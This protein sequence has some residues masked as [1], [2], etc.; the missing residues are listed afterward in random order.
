ER[1]VDDKTRRAIALWRIGVLGSLVSARLE[2]GDRVRLF[3]EIAARVYEMPP[4]GELVELSPR[5]IES[6]Y[7]VYK[8]G[9]FE[10]LRPGTRSDCGKSRAITPEV[11]EL[12][13][14]A[15]R[16]KPRRSLNRLIRMLERAKVVKAGELKRSSVHRLLKLANISARPV[17][18]PSAERRS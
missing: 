13:L 9:G 1:A 7:Y 5:T 8:H 6:W 12:I 15:K 16:E 2:H 10:A 18:G 17:R 4:D 14:R 3:E 11:A